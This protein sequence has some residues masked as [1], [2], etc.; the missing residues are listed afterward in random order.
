MNDVAHAVLRFWFGEAPPFVSRPVWFRKDD[1]FDHE[2]AQRFGTVIEQALNGELT[3][4]DDNAESALA[5]V[6]VLDQLPRNMFRNTPRAFAGDAQALRTARAMLARG[7]DQQLHPPQR[8]FVYLPFEHAESPVVQEESLRLFGALRAA[9]AD[10]DDLLDY[11]KR[12]HA[13]IARFGRFPHRNATLGR[14]STPEET[15]FLS[16][17]GSGF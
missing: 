13:I 11:A 3:G 6:I 14:E 2:I 4:W 9:S 10:A 1:A 16:Q 12:H 5:H 7:D 15:A 8:L 17:P